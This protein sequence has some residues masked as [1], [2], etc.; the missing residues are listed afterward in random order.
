[1]ENT[2]HRTRFNNGM[3]RIA[4]VF[5][6]KLNDEKAS[7]YWDF[8]SRKLTIQQFESAVEAW[9]VTG[10]RFPMIKNLLDAAPGLRGGAPPKTIPQIIAGERRLYGFSLTAGEHIDDGEGCG[11]GAPTMEAAAS[12]LATLGRHSLE[13]SCSQAVW[14][15]VER[16]RPIPRPLLRAWRAFRDRGARLTPEEKI[17]I[18][19]MRLHYEGACTIH[20][21]GKMVEEGAWARALDYGRSQLQALDRLFPDVKFEAQ[22]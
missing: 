4:A 19:T 12:E 2:A 5:D 11:E 21:A 18:E 13:I 3:R 6:R 7:I 10:E 22:T 17:K 9:V 8:L 16:Q 20:A 14:K 15:Y 1:M